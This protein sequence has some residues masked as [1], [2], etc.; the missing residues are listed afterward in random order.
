MTCDVLAPPPMLSMADIRKHF[1][2]LNVLQGVNAELAAGRVTAVL[3][4]NGTG[5]TTLLKIILGLTTPS[6]GTLLVNGH[7]VGTDPAYRAKIGYMPQIARFPENLSGADL[8]SMLADLRGVDATQDRELVDAFRL[9][10]DLSKPMRTLSGGTRQKL[11]ASLAFLFS[12]ELFVLDEP[13]ASLDPI[14]SGVLK[15]K[16][17]AERA[18]GKT[19]V[20]TSHVMSDIEELA[21]DILLLVDGVARFVGSV[22]ELKVRTRQLHLEKAVAQVMRIAEAAA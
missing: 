12:P 11:N 22:Q 20:L 13:T 2:T 6:S 17:R 21:D 4:A 1:G 14:S 10:A 8:L 7:R 16:I 15:E 3:G 9:G 18:H 5:K 19:F